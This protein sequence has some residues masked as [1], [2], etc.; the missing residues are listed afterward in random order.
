MVEGAG[1]NGLTESFEPI[2]EVLTGG[3]ADPLVNDIIRDE[4][5]EI[6]RSYHQ[7]YDHLQELIQNAVDAC[8]DAYEINLQKSQKYKPRIEVTFDLDNNRITVDDNGTGMNKDTLKKYYF[9]P[10]AGRK[11]RSP[12]GKLRRGEKGV[13]ATFLSYGSHRIWVSTKPMDNP[14]TY[15][16]CELA[17]GID[18]IRD[19]SGALS[20]PRVNPVDAHPDLASHKHGTIIVIDLNNLTNLRT[21]AKHGRTVKDW[22]AILRLFTAIGFIG[23]GIDGPAPTD[24]LR[25]LRV[26]VKVIESGITTA[27]KIDTGYLYPHLV[28]DVTWIRAKDIKRQ[29]GNNRPVSRCSMRDM[30]IEWYGQDQIKQMLT[31]KL[32]NPKQQRF[33][34]KKDAIIQAIDRHK[35][36][37]YVG[38]TYSAEFWDVVN[39]RIFQTSRSEITHGMIFATRTHRVGGN[40]GIDFSGNTTDFNRFSLVIDMDEVPPDIGRKSIPYEICD[41]A[42]LI[43]DAVHDSLRQ[44]KDCL[45]PSPSSGAAIGAIQVDDI[46]HMA[47]DEGTD[48]DVDGKLDL[49]LVK[50]PREE[51]DVIALFFELLGK[52]HIKGY[53]VFATKLNEKYDSVAEFSLEKDPAY[54]YDETANRL[55][56]P[57]ERFDEMGGTMRSPRKQILEFKHNSDQLINDVEYLVKDVKDIHWLVC[58][59]IG[60]R[61]ERLGIDIVD[62]TEPAQK[63]HR[64]Y[65]GETHLLTDQ[66]HSNIRI[67]ALKSVVHLLLHGMG[68]V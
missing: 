8:E 44:N 19:Y 3:T 26:D 15:N 2:S 9:T 43:A 31:E 12:S 21:L 28:K 5:T 16:A 54:F 17:G 64:W 60:S 20:M 22:E 53:R 4:I 66:A 34:D 65:Y 33:A 62:V 56:I 55:G 37:A 27:E 23:I 47:V 11:K 57:E 18:W 50:E 30:I 49:A 45:K 29:A 67:I 7:T 59:D 48:L 68:G 1:A 58:W 61:H 35:P 51:Q 24:F 32:N 13:G 25:A 42:Q 40:V 6:L 63:N 38:F 41:V 14:N 52:G 46:R 36:R 39:K 10:F